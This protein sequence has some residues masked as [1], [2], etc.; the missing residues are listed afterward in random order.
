MPGQEQNGRVCAVASEAAGGLP[1]CCAADP[2]PGFERQAMDA[3]KLVVRRQAS[4]S[5]ALE[6][7]EAQDEEVVLVGEV[8]L[9]VAEFPAEGNRSCACQG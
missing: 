8:T 3:G 4:L 7:L 5:L 9:K 1:V 2:V 6:V